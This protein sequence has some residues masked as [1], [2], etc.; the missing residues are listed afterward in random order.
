[1]RAGL[2]F[3]QAHRTFENKIAAERFLS[4]AGCPIAE[5]RVAP[6]SRALFGALSALLRTCGLVLVV[7][8]AARGPEGVGEPLA[9]G[10]LFGRLGVERG[11]GG[12]RGVLRLREADGCADLLESADRAVFVLPDEPGLLGVLLARGRER[13]A[14]KFGAGF[15]REAACPEEGLSPRSLERAVDE[16]LGAARETSRL[17]EPIE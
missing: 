10:P 2:I 11:P 3:Y 17:T 12:P 14:R 5:T 7:S 1:M 15:A 13:L 16:S 8:A 9:S 6:D 4:A